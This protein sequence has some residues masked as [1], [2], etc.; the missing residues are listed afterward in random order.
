MNKS[1]HARLSLSHLLGTG[2]VLGAL[3]VSAASAQA[4]APASSGEAGQ[5]RSGGVDAQVSPA[6]AYFTDTLVVDQNGQE[7]RFYSDLL[8]G[9]VVVVNTIFTTC[10]GICPVMGKTFAR[11]QDHLGDQLG[12]DV[13]LI[14]I[15]VDPE[16][17][18]PEKLREFAAKFGGRPGWYLITGRKENVEF[19]LHRL[20]QRV[21]AKEDHKA[22]L[23]VGNEPTGLW[24]KVFA[25]ANPDEIIEIIDGVI[26][27]EEGTAGPR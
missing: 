8:Q 17:D 20:G 6:A 22:L 5:V 23:L 7:R 10:T 21:D 12:K 2:L 4:P 14:S 25:L 18:T 19:I 1:R 27:D 9:K 13:R 24:K 3:A 16:N 26:R 11:V 15:S